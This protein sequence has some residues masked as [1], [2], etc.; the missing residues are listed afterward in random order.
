MSAG[1]TFC[2]SSKSCEKWIFLL[3]VFLPIS[4]QNL[5]SVRYLCFFFSSYQTS[6]FVC[7]HGANVRCFTKHVLLH[8]SKHKDTHWVITVGDQTAGHSPFYKCTIRGHRACTWVNFL[9]QKLTPCHRLDWLPAW[10]HEVCGSICLKYKPPQQ[11]LT[12]IIQCKDK[13]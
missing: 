5:N 2:T 9:P 12:N 7:Q 1:V 6:G 4:S 3:F 11:L 10:S 8:I 13:G